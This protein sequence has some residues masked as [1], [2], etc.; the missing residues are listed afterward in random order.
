MD[1]AEDVRYALAREGDILG[2]ASFI[3]AKI[4]SFPI[5]EREDI[6]E[7]RIRVWKRDNAAHR[8]H[9]KVRR[10]HPV[11]LQQREVARGGGMNAGPLLNRLEP[12]D[13]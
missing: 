4:E 10:E 1:I 7:E 12:G 11:L 8:N 5:E 2:R 13:R 9:E 3:E 6:M